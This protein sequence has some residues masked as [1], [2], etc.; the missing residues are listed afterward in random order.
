MQLLGR[1]REREVLGRVLEAAREGRST[2]VA[3]YGEPGVGKTA[4]LESAAEA[5]SDFQIGRTIGAE[6]E[7]ELAFAA[8]QQLCSPNLDLTERLP[9]PQREALEVALGLSTGRAP[10]LFFLGL[11][12]LNLLSEAADERPILFVVDDA[13]W[14]DR[15]SAGV[16]AFV[17]RRLLGERIAMVFAAREPIAWLGR[18]AELHVEPL[19]TEQRGGC[20]GRAL[21]VGGVRGR[22]ADRGDPDQGLQV[23]TDRGQDVGDTGSEIHPATLGRGRAPRARAGP[24]STGPRG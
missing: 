2:V 1:Q 11:A 4:L 9:D 19:G 22:G 17:A 14:L 15:G 20:L 3:V 7:M 23:G 21:H 5:A 8:L 10:N 16:L 24:S 18:A 12:V 6:G 13:Q